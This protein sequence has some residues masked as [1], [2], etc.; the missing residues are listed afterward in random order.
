[1]KDIDVIN[2]S[3]ETRCAV[4]NPWDNNF[5]NNSYMRI[6]IFHPLSYAM[7]SELIPYTYE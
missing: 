1:M 4:D 6:S 3:A 7:K 5:N 2:T